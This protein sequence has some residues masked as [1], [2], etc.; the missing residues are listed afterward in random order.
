MAGLMAIQKELPKE[1]WKVLRL[2]SLTGILLEMCLET[3][4]VESKA[5]S[6]VW[7]KV[8]LMDM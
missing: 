3:V 1:N 4:M 2:E 6:T 8:W 7:K 5:P